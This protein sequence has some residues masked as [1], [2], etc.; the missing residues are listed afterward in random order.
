MTPDSGDKFQILLDVGSKYSAD[1]RYVDPERL[2][3]VFLS[4]IHLDHTAFIGQLLRMLKKV[5]RTIPLPIYCQAHTWSQ[6]KILI[7]LACGRI[8]SFVRWVPVGLKMEDPYLKSHSKICHTDF[9][10]IRTLEPLQFSDALK[11]GISAAPAKH[12]SDSV[13]FRFKIQDSTHQLD[14]L[15]TPDT[16][17]TSTHLVPFA[18]KADYWLLDA[19]YPKEEIERRFAKFERN[20][21]GGEIVCHSSPQH[22]GQL[23]ATAGVKTYVVVHFKW[24]D[25]AATYGD[26]EKNM[27]SLIRPIYSGNVIVTQDLRPVE[28]TPEKI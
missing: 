4:H 11:M 13:A 16:S 12:S 22:S 26:L 25:Y 27:L 7:W 10:Q 23:C 8:P 2:T 5:K 3:A 1:P 20:E 21:R 17:Y 14:F 15:F 9:T 24:P 19:G 28:M 18:K 6:I